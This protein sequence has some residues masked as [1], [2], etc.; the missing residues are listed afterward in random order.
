MR[1]AVFSDLNS[2]L[3]NACKAYRH[4]GGIDDFFEFLLA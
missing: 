2:G 4:A 3:L 1:L